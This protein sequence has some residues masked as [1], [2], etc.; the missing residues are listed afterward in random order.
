LLKRYPNATWIGVDLSLQMLRADPATRA[1]LGQR[2]ASL[3][4]A[5]RTHHVCAD[6]SVLPL[7][8]DTV[9]LAFS[10]LM[11]HWHPAPHTV[12]PEWKR[13]LRIG[14]LLMFSCFGPDTLKQLRAAIVR[15]L[16]GA[17]PWP[18]VDMH[19][20]GDMMV[21]SGFATP[22]MDV[23]TLTLT[24]PSP[25]SLLREVSALG[26]NPCDDRFPGLASTKQAH[27][28]LAALEAQRGADGRIALSFEVAYGHAWK[29]QP[30][31]S[32]QTTIALDHLRAGLAAHRR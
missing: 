28:L 17:R 7:A 23:E 12:F 11:L 18:F 16:P 21:A 20:F 22:V 8:D 27:A 13:V 2:F 25:Q 9:D 31:V 29:P 4:R 1:G 26:G 15:T 19:D 24:Y 3:L 10:N 32:G 6:A 5:P 30:R 14:G